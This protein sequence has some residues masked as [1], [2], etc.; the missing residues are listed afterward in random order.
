VS[1]PLSAKVG[2]NFSDKPRSLG[3]FSSLA[4]SG[5]R[6]PEM[7]HFCN[8]GESCKAVGICIDSRVDLL[9]FWV[10]LPGLAAVSACVHVTGPGVRV[11]L[12]RKTR[13]SVSHVKAVTVRYVTYDNAINDFM[14]LMQPACSGRLVGCVVRWLLNMLFLKV[15]Y[16]F[17]SLYKFIQ[18]ACS[19]F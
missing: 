9:F 19:V 17:E 11:L 1:H 6:V 10:I 12:C 5:H 13:W 8:R 4:D 7:S 18:R 15:L 2:I 3:R 16:K 14:C